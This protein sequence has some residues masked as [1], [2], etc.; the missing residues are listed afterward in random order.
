M[1]CDPGELAA[2]CAESAHYSSGHYCDEQKMKPLVGL[3]PALVVRTR[4]ISRER[5]ANVRHNCVTEQSV[6]R[7]IVNFSRHAAIARTRLLSHRRSTSA[8]LWQE[9]AATLAAVT[10]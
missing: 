7:R 2:G 10:T 1:R 5:P 8:T 3:V 6:R 9:N 4:S